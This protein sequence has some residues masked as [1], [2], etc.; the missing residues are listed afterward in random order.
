LIADVVY[1]NLVDDLD[2]LAFVLQLAVERD[3]SEGVAHRLPRDRTQNKAAQKVA[4]AQLIPSK[5]RFNRTWTTH[6]SSFEPDKKPAAG[7]P[8][9]GLVGILATLFKVG[10]KQPTNLPTENPAQESSLLAIQS[11]YRHPILKI[12]GWC[13]I[14]DVVFSNP[15]SNTWALVFTKPTLPNQ[16]RSLILLRKGIHVLPR[17]SKQPEIQQFIQSYHAQIEESRKI[18]SG[19]PSP[20]IHPG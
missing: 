14:L 18:L 4:V 16:M 7:D 9:T 19:N 12:K 11:H 15:P 1:V 10:C 8:A 17:L 3:A 6:F 20:S 2:I 5:L 13:Y